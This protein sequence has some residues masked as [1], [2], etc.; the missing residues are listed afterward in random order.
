MVV[1]V[2]DRKQGVLT[3]HGWNAFEITD[4]G[5]E[6]LEKKEMPADIGDQLNKAIQSVTKI[7]RTC[8]ATYKVM[9]AVC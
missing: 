8:E 4:K 5:V 9:S 6:Q 1:E 2:A 3:Q 7:Y